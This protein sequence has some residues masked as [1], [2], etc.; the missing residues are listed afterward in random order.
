MVTT[1]RGA[2]GVVLDERRDRIGLRTITVAQPA[3]E[4][5]GGT[6]FQFVLNGVPIFARG[7]NWVPAS[8]LPGSIGDDKYR[9]LVKTARHGAMNMLRGWGGGL[10][11]PDVFF[12]ACDEEGIL[13]WQDFMFACNDYDSSD[14]TLA[15]EVALEAEF[16]VRR[17]RNHASL[18][19]WCG[20]N[21]VHALHQLAF[22]NV[23]KGDWGWSFFHETLPTAV[24]SHSGET[25]Y[26]PGSPYGDETN[27][28]GTVDGD[29]HAWEVWHGLTGIGA[30]GPTTFAS[31]G[32]AV[33]WKRYAHDKG[34]FNSEFGIHAS[35]DLNTLERWTPAGSLALGSEQFNHRNKDN[36]KDKGNDLMEL[37][38][39]LPAD[40][41]EYVAF[42]MACQ[43]EGLKFGI[44]HYRRRQPHCSGTLVWQFNDPW[45][46]TTWS[47][48]DYDL[49]P[50]AGYWFMQQNHQPVIAT[51]TT[52]EDGSLELWVTNSSRS[53]HVLALRVEIALFAGG[54]A[55]DEHVRVTSEPGSS[56][57]VWTAPA[58]Q[59]LGAAD[60]FAHVSEATG[61]VSA[62][63]LFFGHLKELP[64]GAGRV[65]A[66]VGA[67]ADGS[68]DVEL[69]ATGYAYFVSICTP[70]TGVVY[71]RNY[72]ELRD[73]ESLTIEVSGLP[74]DFDVASLQISSWGGPGAVSTAA[75][76]QLVATELV[77]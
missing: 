63:R 37:E 18:A 69:T 42:S 14:A 6:L 64:L 21:E 24:A 73:G 44:E 56:V 45:P 76:P 46:G 10:Y 68:L 5:E 19:L 31:H 55:L 65:S 60:R 34:K 9:A 39:G 72:V 29:R 57:R 50:K 16:Q 35:P 2:A 61:L 36:P 53:A 77:P 1:L 58:D 66:V 4:V 74:T 43:A 71:S 59:V 33:H 30:D 38:T 48:V 32:E 52:A 75:A 22:G 20:N 54:S 25:F 67:L 23:E 26:W 7:A 15:A 41:A 11:E 51:F 17:L 70:L 8:M 49:V 3:D 28:N 40:L 13:V 27:I 62:N 47:V 12:D